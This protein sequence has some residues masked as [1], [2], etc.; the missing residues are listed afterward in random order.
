MM[1]VY[2]DDCVLNEARVCEMEVVV[3]CDEYSALMDAEKR[4]LKS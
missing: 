3:V 2:D 4:G 1:R